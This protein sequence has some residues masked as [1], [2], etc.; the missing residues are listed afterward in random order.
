M[1]AK[2]TGVSPALP[3]KPLLPPLSG[4]HRDEGGKERRGKGREEGEENGEKEEKERRG[5]WKVRGKNE[6]KGKKATLS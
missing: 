2:G 4:N 5:A 6:K 3:L 1:V